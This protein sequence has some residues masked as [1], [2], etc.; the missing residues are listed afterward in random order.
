[1][2]VTDPDFAIPRK[3]TLQERSGRSLGQRRNLRKKDYGSLL[4][5]VVSCAIGKREVIAAYFYSIRSGPRDLIYQVNG[6]RACMPNV[7]S[8]LKDEA[9]RPIKKAG[10]MA[11]TCD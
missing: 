3:R 5:R 6:T 11:T 8:M 9:L 4:A 2:P 7:T 10:L 1:M